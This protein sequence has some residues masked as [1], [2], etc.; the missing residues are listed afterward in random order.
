VTVTPAA[1]QSG[2]TTITLTVSDGTA[3]ASTT[4]ELTVTPVNDPPAISTI[5]NQT[6]DE[7]TPT[8]PIA[9]TVSDVDNPAGSLVVTGT[10]SNETLVPNANVVTGGSNENRNVVVT[11]VNGQGGTTTITLTVSD[12]TATATGTFN[13]VVSSVNDAPTISAIPAQSTNEDVPTGQISF[14]VGDAETA[15]ASLI[16]TGSSSNKTLVP[17]ANIVI[18][19][20]GDTRTVVLNPAL[21]QNGT[22]EITLTVSDGTAS[23]Q[24]TF[25]LTV[26]PVNDPP[27]VAA[28]KPLNTAENTP[29]TL[30]IDDFTIQDPD[31]APG[32]MTL[33]VLP[34]SLFQVNGNTITPPLNFKGQLTVLV[35]V[36]DRALTSPL[37]PVIINVSDVNDPP[38]IL[39]QNDL[40]KAVNTQFPI[41]ISD[42]QVQDADEDDRDNLVVSALPGDNYLVGGTSN[43]LITP[44]QDFLGELEIPVVV[45]DGKATSEPF[46]LKVTIFLPGLQPSITGQESLIMLEDT[47]Y[48]LEF[49][50]LIV[51][52]ADTE[53]P[54]GFTMTI[55]GGDNYTVAGRTITPALNF[56]ND[57][58]EIPVT[59]HDGTFPSNR[60][61]VRIFVRPVNDPPEITALESTTIFYEPGSGPV[62]ITETFECI[63][64]DSEFLTLAE[65]RLVDPFFSRDNDEL[66]F[67]NSEDSPIRG[68]YDEE[69][70]ELSLVGYATVDDYIAAVR[71]IQYNY[72]LTTDINGE[73]SPISTEPKGVEIRLGDGEFT[74]EPRT[75]TI[76][77][78][79]LVDLDIANTF[80]PNGDASNDT[81]AIEPLQ[82]SDRFSDTVVKVY[83][84]RGLLVWETVGLDT[85]NRWDGTYN[86][87]L[88]PPDTYYYT[89][90]LNLSFIKKTY[91]GAVMILY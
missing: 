16:V 83:N 67:E 1:D 12:G 60:Y 21:N 72:R 35:R 33:E 20:G 52:D 59:V 42:L 66:I 44:S 57:I 26:N 36:S 10:S 8:P 79:T 38:V 47:P 15:A 18:S 40:N 6:T 77:L 7:S 48:E 78:E 14:T 73:P 89:I 88:L 69:T 53:Y 34:N 25:Q 68:I 3:T 24:T 63:D 91:K 90:D 29:I 11:P 41:L 30:T 74:S 84:K 56:N 85:E 17:D 27:I 82:R 80:T 9:F 37:F 70:G 86:G 65:I 19:N 51:S 22:S 76:E 5:A 75:R 55:E 71:S 62:P 81:W 54:K 2:T 61:T 28:Q 64:V 46:I 43:N 49:L 45:S 39:G 50:D 87:K 32:S 58:L 4:F 23:A 31:N 13:V